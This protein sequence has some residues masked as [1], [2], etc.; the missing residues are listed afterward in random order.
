MSPSRAICVQ[1]APSWRHNWAPSEFTVPTQSWPRH[2]VIPRTEELAG[3]P[4]PSA[5]ICVHSTP[6]A[7]R[8]TSPPVVAFSVPAWIAPPETTRLRT[9][10]FATSPKPPATTRAQLEPS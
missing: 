7:E 6:S 2:S 3:S 8:Q 5:L 4:K 10:S 1:V 9:P